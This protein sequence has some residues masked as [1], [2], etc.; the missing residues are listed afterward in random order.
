MEFGRKMLLARLA[1]DECSAT[2]IEHGLIAAGI[3]KYWQRSETTFTSG[4]T[5]LKKV[6]SPVVLKGL[7]CFSGPS[8]FSA[9]SHPNE[10]LHQAEHALLRRALRS[11]RNGTLRLTS[12]ARA[13]SA[14]GTSRPS[15]LAVLRL[16]TSSNLVGCST[17]RSVDR[18]GQLAIEGRFRAAVFGQRPLTVFRYTANITRGRAFCWRHR[19]NFISRERSWTWPMTFWLAS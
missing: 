4:Q 17:G 7:D 8:L 13:S 10:K 6:H 2:V 9:G 12:S 18:F 19:A 15:A 1:Q 11:Q 16:M 5:A 3:S 14:G